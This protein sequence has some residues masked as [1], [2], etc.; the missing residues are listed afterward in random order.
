M[1]CLIAFS[2]L[3][4]AKT[5]AVT[6]TSN[7]VVKRSK[8]KTELKGKQTYMGMQF[9][10]PKETAIF[11]HHYT[12]KIMLLQFCERIILILNALRIVVT[13]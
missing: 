11:F 7:N 4:R 3:S 1:A 12:E 6:M 13:V 10:H 2:G 8:A 5:D 9:N